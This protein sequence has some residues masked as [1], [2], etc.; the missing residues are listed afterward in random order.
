MGRSKKP[1]NKEYPVDKIISK[2]ETPHGVEYKVVWKGNHKDTWEPIRCLQNAWS[3][4]AD[5]E[6]GRRGG[7]G[8]GGTF[9]I[10]G[11]RWMTERAFAEMAASI[12]DMWRRW[13]RGL[14][15]LDE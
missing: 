8:G 4:I 10:G 11:A 5:Y 9:C 14:L 1:G 2:R 6:E 7:S 15:E 12:A 13:C 3:A